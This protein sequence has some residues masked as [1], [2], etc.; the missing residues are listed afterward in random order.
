MAAQ[1]PPSSASRRA[2]EGS[3]NEVPIGRYLRLDEIGRGSFAT[4]Y[5]GIHS[6]HRSYVAIKSVNL[7]KL[8]KKLKD[9]LS[10]EIDILKGLHHPHIVALIDCHESTS[11]IHLVMEYCAL[12]DL[13][14]FI[15]RRETLGNHRYTRDMI[16]KYPNPRV[17]ALNEVIV[18]HFLKQLS[19]ALKFLRDRNLIHRD[20][21]PQNLLLCP[22]PASYRNG[23]AQIIPFKGSEDSF[24]PLAGLD[25]LP[26]LK[27]ADFGFARSLPSTSLAETLCG[28]PLY[29][30]PEI[31][32][33]EKYDAKADLW[34]VGTVLYEMV[35]GK[36]PFRAS[37]HVELLRKI[38][39]GEDKIRFP[40]E[41]EASDDIKKLIKGL[42]KRNPVERMTFKDFFESPV[43][44]DE[45]P[46]LV[47][48][49]L[50]VTRRH[51]S[52]DV[53]AAGPNQTRPDSRESRPRSVRDGGAFEEVKEPPV[54]GRERSPAVPQQP[55]PTRLDSPKA[56]AMRRIG[57]GDKLA[58]RGDDLQR[59]A[60][61]ARQTPPGR[62]ESV[63]RNPTP[64]A[65][66]ERKKGRVPATPEASPTA[67]QEARA[68]EERERAAQDVAFERDYVVVEKRA[69]EVNA[70]ADELAN[71]P[72][73]RA[74]VSNQGTPRQAGALT[75]RATV[76]NV[77]TAAGNHQT[78]SPKAA[79]TTGGRPRAD[80]HHRQGSYERRY[81]QSPSSATSAISKALNMAS[82]RLFGVGFSPPLTLGK[83][84]RSPPLAYNPYPA[85]PTAQ[86][87]LVLAGDGQKGNAA[88]DED[89]KVVQSIE[90]CA[91][92]SD[93]VYGFAEVKYKQLIPLTPSVQ[94]D[95]P[96]KP[97]TGDRGFAETDDGE[98][99][100]DAIVTLSEEALVLYVKALSLLAKSMDIAGAWWARKNR[101]DGLAE[102]KEGMSATSALVGTRIN[103]VVQWVRSR[104]NEVLEKAEF[105]RLKLIEA[106][107]RLPPD[108]P[109]H[110]NNHPTD[111]T[112]VGGL[113]TSADNVVVSSGVT[114]EK[115]MYDRAL[116]MSRAA[117][118]NELTGEDLPGCEIAYV[119]AIR[120]LEAVLETD[121]LP[122]SGKGGEKGADADKVVLDGVQVEDRKVVMKRKYFCR[123]SP[124][125]GIRDEEI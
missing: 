26:M 105:V 50:P 64:P 97:A 82:G 41:I 16:A 103:N 7:S 123:S 100:P 30:A 49:D 124:F 19:S 108:H 32:R 33:Y 75:R 99:T 62:Q 76:Q 34:S 36:P 53:E 25:S 125:V 1:R 71:S 85:Y 115:L 61:T 24:T 86:Q 58:A 66:A 77:S 42:L 51:P 60:V 48:D 35:V 55:V 54:A 43:I 119:T 2:R 88:V 6:K 68:R 23:I 93:V 37:N 111:T 65:A 40:E 83:G 14:L 84:G 67:D 56:D 120:M 92:R 117:A 96:D 89:T 47:G 9:N 72:R 101:G 18:R 27:I 95:T 114:A 107:K 29:M 11:H 15:K 38:E 94:T 73:I 52:A 112:S 45:I 69:V 80:S 74:G 13:S 122:R 79:Q 28:S 116:E 21:K 57:S 70:F 44:K 121:E 110:P 3:H 22:S 87:S 46:G 17:G 10:S 78:S 12:G 4:V 5:Q 39:K 81:G 59:A 113:G 8:N 109:S 91:T 31:L 90:E 118:I 20:I 63:D 104:F 106:Q 102:G 98:L